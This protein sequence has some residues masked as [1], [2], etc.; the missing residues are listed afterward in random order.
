MKKYI[1]YYGREDDFQKSIAILLDSYSVLWFHPPNGGK[2]SKS[3]GVKFKAMGVKAGVPDVV[4]CEPCGAYHGFFIELKVD[5]GVV[6]KT[7]KDWLEALKKR[8]YKIA[9]AWS[10]DEVEDLLRE[11]LNQ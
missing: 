9:V 8:N 10:I 5:G 1:K 2:R 3:E 6:R 11:Y 4:I 7:Q